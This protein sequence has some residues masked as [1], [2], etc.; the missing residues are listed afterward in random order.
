M[1]VSELSGALLDYWVARAEGLK[2]FF[3]ED[4][5][6]VLVGFN[7]S[8]DPAGDTT[9]PA[10]YA[11]SVAWEDG[12]PIIQKHH[13]SV[14]WCYASKTWQADCPR[15]KDGKFVGRVQ[16]W[17]DTDEPLVAAMRCFVASRFGDEVDDELADS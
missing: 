11:P 3:L 16:Q 13:I 4:D 15:F 9:E 8:T 6:C 2:P 7:S 1:K 17:C 14:G 10:A 12:G 5:C